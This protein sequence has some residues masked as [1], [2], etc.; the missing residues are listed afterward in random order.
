MS[1]A[2]AQIDIIAFDKQFRGAMSGVQKAMVR[3]KSSMEGVSRAARRVLLA[4]SV[5]IGVFTKLAATQEKAE[6]DLAAALR[7]IGPAA[8]EGFEELKKFASAIQAVTTIG[9]EDVL[10]LMKLGA[11]MGKLSGQQLKDATQAAI[12]LSKAFAIE[13]KGAMLLVARAAVGDTTMLKRY[14]III[15]AAKS[16][17]EKFNDVLKIGLSNF[18]L[19]TAEVDTFSGAMAQLKNAVGDTGEQIGGALLPDLKQLI[20][21]LRD[22]NAS[23]QEWVKNNRN[24]IVSITKWTVGISAAAVAIPLL[25]IGLINVIGSLKLM[26]VAVAAVVA[27]IGGPWT[28]AIGVAG[29][30]L[31]ALGVKLAAAKLGFDDLTSAAKKNASELSATPGAVELQSQL[32]VTPSRKL[33]VATRQY[34][35]AVLRVKELNKSLDDA[36]KRFVRGDEDLRSSVLTDRFLKGNLRRA[37]RDVTRYKDAMDA[38]TAAA[39]R[40]ADMVGFL[41]DAVFGHLA[42]ALDVGLSKFRSWLEVQGKATERLKQ[43]RREISI[44]RGAGTAAGFEVED[45]RAAGVSSGRVRSIE[46]A[47]ADLKEAQLDKDKAPTPAAPFGSAGRLESLQD[48]F[49]RITQAAAGRRDPMLLAAT[50]NTSAN[51]ST[52]THTRSAVQL[53]RD[54]IGAVNNLPREIN[55][56]PVFSR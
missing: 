15:D 30:A 11:T 16:N 17:T 4:G 21:V 27:V 32:P 50:Q 36:L 22:A 43:L 12:G 54:L 38:A 47:L 26:A 49:R 28:V 10:M 29:A 51:K 42:P 41:G 53:L 1:N 39:S 52:E 44:A 2:R 34:E 46:R 45:L 20:T 37:E 14:G 5:A 48:T 24:A 56:N 8:E 31:T 13:L 3:V 6:L 9:D 23:V 33:S 7:L 18:E 25:S 35:A 40:Q 55:R 19:A